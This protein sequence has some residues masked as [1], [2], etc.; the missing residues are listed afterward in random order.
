LVGKKVVMKA[1]HLVAE[2][3]ASSA[4]M[5]AGRMGDWRVDLMV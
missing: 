5:M 1:V 2:Q 3:A 4:E